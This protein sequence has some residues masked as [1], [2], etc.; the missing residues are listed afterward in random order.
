VTEHLAVH[1]FL[2]MVQSASRRIAVGCRHGLFRHFHLPC[3]VIPLFHLLFTSF[4]LLR[5]TSSHPLFAPRASFWPKGELGGLPVMG[6]AL[7]E[8]KLMPVWIWVY[9]L[10]W[11]LIQVGRCPS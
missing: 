6:L 7:G 1:I 8:Y 9:C 11:W 4:R 10:L 3:K 5:P 2:G